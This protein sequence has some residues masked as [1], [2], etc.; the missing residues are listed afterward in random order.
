MSKRSR[1]DAWLGP[2]SAR[3]HKRGVKCVN[4]G[5][6]LE[7]EEHIPGE[8]NIALRRIASGYIFFN[9]GLGVS[10]LP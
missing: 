2:I 10:N 7:M 1:S 4:S 3:D 5:S 9:C 8:E 6:T